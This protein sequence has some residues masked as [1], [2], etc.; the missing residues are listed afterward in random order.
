[1]KTV[2]LVDYGVG[3]TA[4]VRRAFARLGAAVEFTP[5]PDK[6]AA[7]RRIVL[8]GV[9]AFGPARQRLSE[10]GMDRALK[11]A[12]DSGARLLGLCLGFQLLFEKSTEFGEHE[13]LGFVPGDVRPFDSGVRVP[14]IGWNALS[15][16]GPSR[17]LSRIGEGAFVYFVHSYRPVSVPGPA[18]AATCDYGGGFVAAIEAGEV[19]GCQFHPEKSSVLGQRILESFLSEGP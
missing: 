19:W 7:S 1:M 5:D 13:G 15:K 12:V 17:L 4:S 16:P 10:T 9:G 14:H 6:V 3:N 18:V 8:P 2:T 11:C